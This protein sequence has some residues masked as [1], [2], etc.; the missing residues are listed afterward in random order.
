MEELEFRMFLKRRLGLC[1]DCKHTVFLGDGGIRCRKKRR[2][3][4]TGVK[5][6]RYY[7]RGE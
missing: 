7:E 1:Y 4:Y 2:V 6:C 5:K 3:Y